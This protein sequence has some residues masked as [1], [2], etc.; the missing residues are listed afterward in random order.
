MWQWH[1]PLIP[2]FR[3][4]RQWDL[5]EFEVSLL[6]SSRTAGATQRNRVSQAGARGGKEKKKTSISFRWTLATYIHTLSP[7]ERE[8]MSEQTQETAETDTFLSEYIPGP[9]PNSVLGY[10]AFRSKRPKSHQ[11]TSVSDPSSLPAWTNRWKQLYCQSHWFGL[12]NFQ[13]HEKNVCF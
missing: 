2:A 6:V 11:K 4:Q 3:R 5:Y 10:E 12:P 7:N 1:T 13:K 9:C 8:H